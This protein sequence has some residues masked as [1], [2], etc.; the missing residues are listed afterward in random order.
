MDHSPILLSIPIHWASWMQSYLGSILGI[1]YIHREQVFRQKGR[2]VLTICLQWLSWSFEAIRKDILRGWDHISCYS[3]QIESCLLCIFMCLFQKTFFFSTEVQTQ[4]LMHTKQVLYHWTTF[5]V[6]KWYLFILTI[7]QAPLD[8]K[9][10]SKLLIWTTEWIMDHVSYPRNLHLKQNS[11]CG[12]KRLWI[13]SP[14]P[15]FLDR[16]CKVLCTVIWKSWQPGTWE[17]T[18]ANSF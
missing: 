16:P 3:G 9:F 17:L 2:S 10:I 8:H 5:L 11:K 1:N 4:G 15:S 13:K 12:F 7:I 18:P 14:P 6:S